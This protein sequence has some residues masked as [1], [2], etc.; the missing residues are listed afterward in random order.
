[1]LL[2]DYGNEDI[3]PPGNTQPSGDQET[4][5]S[6]FKWPTMSAFEVDGVINRSY[7]PFGA[8]VAV[9]PTYM[10]PALERF[11]RLDIDSHPDSPHPTG[12]W[13]IG[14]SE[15]LP[16]Y[17]QAEQMLHV[18]GT[19][20]PFAAV[21][22]AIFRHHRRSAPAMLTLSSFSRKTACIHTDSTLAS[23]IGRAAMNALAGCVTKPAGQT[24]VLYLPNLLRSQPSWHAAKL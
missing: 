13:P 5:L 23:A 22:A 24:C 8:G 6:E 14:Y 19:Q 7:P 3:S 21:E 2:I 12:G 17:L 18:A 15:L 11:D 4:R 10:P 9:A 1:M 16:Y 20:D